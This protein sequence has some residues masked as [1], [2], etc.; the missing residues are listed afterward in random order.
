MSGFLNKMG[1]INEVTSIK[2][3]SIAESK[4]TAIKN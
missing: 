4:A 3:Q 1:K 2:A